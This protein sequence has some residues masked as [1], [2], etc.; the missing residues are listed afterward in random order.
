MESR[1]V[2][3]VSRRV[4]RPVLWSLGLEGFRSRALRLE[5]LHRLFFVKFCK[6]E[7]LKN[8]FKK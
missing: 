3:S 6:K 8:V 5:T 2:V 4:S 1:D 7:V